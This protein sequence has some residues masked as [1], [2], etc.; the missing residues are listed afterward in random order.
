MHWQQT[1][2]VQAH[3]KAISTLCVM[4]NCL[5]TG[6][7]DAS[8]K[9]SSVKSKPF[10]YKADILYL[11]PWKISL[12]Q[13]FVRAAVLSG[14]EDWVRSLAFRQ[15]SSP[16]SPL[17]L[18]S[19]SQDGTI[20]LW[21]V[22]VFSKPSKPTQLQGAATIEPLS[23]DFL[24]AFEASLGDL[25]D[26]EEGGR[27]ISLK[28]HIL[29]VKS[30]QGGSQQ[31][32]ITFDALLVGHEAGVTAL[33]WR[34]DLPGASSS[35][36]LLST[37]TDSSLILWSPSSVAS[38]SSPDGS[39]SIWI[40]RQR[41]GDIGGQRLGG[42]V[43]GLWARGGQEAMAWGWAGGWRR[44]RSDGQGIEHWEEAAAISGHNGPVKGLDWSS[45]G[46]YLISAGSVSA[47]S[48]WTTRIH[49]AVP[50]KREGVAES[51]HEV[52]RPQVHGYDLLDATFLDALKFVSIADEKVARVFE[53]P[54]GFVHIV[55][56]LE[57]AELHSS[58][59]ERP[60][61]ASVPPL[62]LSNKALTASDPSGNV[63][64]ISDT[65]RRPFEGELASITLWPEVE[66][67]FGHGYE[68]QTNHY[69]QSMS[70]A[71]SNSRRF[72]ATACKATTAEHAV[73]R[74]YDTEK[75]QLFGPV[76]EG[77][78]LTVTRIAFS[79]DDRFVLSVSRDRT[80]RLFENKDGAGFMPIAADKSHARIIW[81]CAWTFEGDAFATAS[82]DKTVRIWKL[83]ET[84][85]SARWA[86]VATLKAKEA[87]TA[88]A[89]TAADHEGKRRLAVGLETGEILIYSGARTDLSK[90]KLDLSLD[91]RY[92]P[93]P[94]PN[95]TWLMTI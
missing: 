52:S 2:T 77:H 49:G 91:S 56:G 95:L 17:V 27:Q 70:L 93:L 85:S 94:H 33:S 7:S 58:K 20:R 13:K 41:F 21:N 28:R 10:R 73:V 51:W 26:A 38:S 25:A 46:E 71:V 22:E 15:S 5:V 23:D 62:G 54:R 84:E 86:P 78:A 44:W 74:V 80:W 4:G 50:N 18:A 68:H 66:K 36:T 1:G 79:P 6:G 35:L 60:L 92:G 82:R 55:S 43:G 76:L 8:V 39:T 47:K 19:G 45:K 12:N 30:E 69:G 75:W 61:G 87:I 83:D 32:S 34:P 9:T 89:F 14:H 65:V 42:F 29:T 53:A 3:S 48:S 64:E 24:D 57:I 37:S 90:W 72:M 81:D 63:Q 16:S 40:N 88:I 59:S 67:V 31:Y 11:S